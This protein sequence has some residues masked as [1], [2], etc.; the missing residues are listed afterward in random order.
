M[1]LE[2]VPVLIGRANDQQ[3]QRLFELLTNALRDPLPRLRMTASVILE[4]LG[5]LRA[6]PSLQAA[7]ARETDEGCIRAMNSSLK[8]LQS[9]QQAKQP[10]GPMI[11]IPL[12]N[13]ENLK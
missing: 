2:L 9:K 1:A 6:I 3:S 7:I 13:K 11:A 12:G 5:D 10:V 4:R 8:A